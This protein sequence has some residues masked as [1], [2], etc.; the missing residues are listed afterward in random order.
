MFVRNQ[1]GSILVIVL[2][3]LCTLTIGGAT[4]GG[5]A[6]NDQK[7]TVRQQKN[8]EAFYLARS[9]AEAVATMLLENQEN[10]ED[11][12]GQTTSSELGNG[13]FEVKVTSDGGGVVL[14]ESTGFSGDYSERVTLS[15]VKDDSG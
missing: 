12:I 6:I 9:G 15:L 3:V 2:V 11:Y 13:R 14:I 8:N 4:L 10:I 1:K 5:M 7:Q